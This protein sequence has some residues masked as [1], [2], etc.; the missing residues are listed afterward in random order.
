MK[1]IQSIFCVD[2]HT[3]GPPIRVVTGGIPPLKG[4]TVNDKMLYMEKHYDWIR[5]CVATP[6]RAPE[7]LVCGVLVPPTSGEADFG[8]FYLDKKGYQPMCG[9]GTLSVTKVIVECGLVQRTEPVTKVTF[10]TPSG[11]V[12]VFAEIKDGEV[13]MLS[14]ENA[15]AF[16]YKKDVELEV[17]ELGRL[18][19]DICFGGNFFAIV[20][21]A[22]LPVPLDLAHKDLFGDYMKKIVKAVETQV[23]VCH[24]ENPALNYLN[25]VLFYKS[26]AD[27]NGGYTCQ[28]VFGEAQLDL[29]PC[30]TGT[31]A[32]LAQRF[33]RGLIGLNESF[34]QN[35]IFGG[36]FYA[37]ALAQ[38]QVGNLPAIVPKVSCS[39]VRITG[40]NQLVVEAGDLHK[41]GNSY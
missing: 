5:A 29:S 1:N 27:A 40:F 36:T 18:T 31:C 33:S 12:K 11:I 7:A 24:P 37:T 39:D 4:D 25:Q 19:V 9:A 21:T 41:C 13:T 6:P 10:E 3:A 22:Q 26:D 35:S 32:R 2:A 17:E 23:P 30:G 14:M 16:L 20:D 15:P 28:C 8:L 34:I 38:T